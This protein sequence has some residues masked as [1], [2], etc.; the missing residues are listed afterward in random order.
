[1]VNFTTNK[2]D[3]DLEICQNLGKKQHPRERRILKV[4]RASPTKSNQVTQQ[5][6]AHTRHKI[7]E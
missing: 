3:L 5:P 6:I 7:P 2:I 1:M 4:M